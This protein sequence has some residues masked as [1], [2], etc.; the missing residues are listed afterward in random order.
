MSFA[1]PDYQ[2]VYECKDPCGLRDHRFEEYGHVED[3]KSSHPQHPFMPP[4]IIYL[5][6]SSKS[7][8]VAVETGCL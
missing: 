8:H 4:Q 3:G 6:F 2:G 1:T 7:D 5:F